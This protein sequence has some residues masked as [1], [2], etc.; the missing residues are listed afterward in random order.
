[1][2]QNKEYGKIIKYNDGTRKIVVNTPKY[3]RDTVKTVLKRD[4]NN[5]QFFPQ[6]S[7]DKELVML[8]I[9]VTPN[10][11]FYA[12]EK[13]QNDVEVY[14]LYNSMENKEEENSKSL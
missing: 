2:D 7:D 13:L 14:N 3:D 5:L 4:G 8:A 1:M 10:A 11:Y 6:Y 12:S 9:S